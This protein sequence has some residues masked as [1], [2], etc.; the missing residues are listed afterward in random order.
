MWPEAFGFSSVV[1]QGVLAVYSGP[2][3]GRF[4]CDL[5]AERSARIAW[6]CRGEL[7]W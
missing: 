3:E 1:I 4:V 6:V 2:F 5:R 7:P